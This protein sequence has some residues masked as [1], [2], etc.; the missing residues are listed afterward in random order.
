MEEININN[1]LKDYQKENLIK[2]NKPNPKWVTDF[3]IW[4]GRDNV[5]VQEFCIYGDHDIAFLRIDKTVLK[6]FTD[7]PKLKNPNNIE[8]GTS[9]CKLWFPFYAVN[10]RFDEATKMF[11]FP[12]DLLPIP[13]F[14]IEGIYTRD[15]ITGK[16]QDGTMDVMYLE[17]SSAGIRGQSGGPIIDM[18]GNIYAVQSKNLTMSL[19]FKGVVEIDGKEIEEN[20]FINVGIGVHI[21]TIVNLLNKHSIKHEII[22]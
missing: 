21:K 11:I 7:F 17:T 8:I 16:S 13:R 15:L 5:N 20:Q 18:E 2:K 4:Y 6:G 3:Q 1:Q 19:G 14:P 10:T 22:T 12:S 9:L